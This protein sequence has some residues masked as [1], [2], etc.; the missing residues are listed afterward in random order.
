MNAN[1]EKVGVAGAGAWG[2]ALACVAARAGRE[3][4]VWAREPEVAEAIGERHENPVFLPGAAL[5][6][7]TASTDPAFLAGCDACLLTTPAQHLRAA[8]A[9]F[10]RT[11]PPEACFIVCAKGF[12]QA[13]GLMMSEVLAEIAPERKV[14][15]LSGPSFAA[16]VVRGLPTAVTLACED[17]ELGNA[18]VAAI[19]LPEFRPYLS[20]DLTG[21]QVGGAVKNVL[22][23]ACGVVEGRRLGE[24]A[25]AALI[26]RGFA[27]LVRLGRA[28]GARAETL[29]GLS[30]LGDLVLTCGS[31][32]SRNMSL[33]IALGEGRPLGEV[34]AERNSVAEGVHTAAAALSLARRHGVEMPITEA[35]ADIV[36]GTLDV[37]EA[38]RALLNRPF[39]TED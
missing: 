10:H 2:T 35:V 16:D 11:L 17:S 33:G 22:A 4:L 1:I 31:P 30:G 14:A 18:L 15:V 26:T 12:E 38:I 7:M 3:V 36:S 37:E 8:A 21:A 5:E 25:R 32:Q 27:E 13:T 28:L 19:G 6:P 9:E 29:R 23:I 24:S 20:S 34:L 39:T